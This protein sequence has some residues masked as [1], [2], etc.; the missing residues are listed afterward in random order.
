MG[1][2]AQLVIVALIIS[3]LFASGC[4]FSSDDDSQESV[5]SIAHPYEFS[6]PKWEFETLRSELWESLKPATKA[7]IDDTETVKE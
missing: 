4:T 7:D 5:S 2:R 6:I 3:I 1:K